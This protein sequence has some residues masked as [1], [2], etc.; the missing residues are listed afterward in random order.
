MKFAAISFVLA[1]TAIAS[2]QPKGEEHGDRVRYGSVAPSRPSNR[3]GWVELV[4]PISVKHG[5][6]FVTVGGKPSR[7][8]QLRI[9][10]AS[11]TVR[12]FWIRMFFDDNTVQTVRLERTLG[13]THASAVI[14]VTPRHALEDIAIATDRHTGGTYTVHGLPTTRIASR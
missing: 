6:E 13:R 3:R 8:S 10:A 4:S 12:V 1:M 14:D 7:F 5:T 11:G 2:A 9:D